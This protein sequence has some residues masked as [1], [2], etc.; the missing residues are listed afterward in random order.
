[1]LQ[2]EKDYPNPRRFSSERFLDKNG[3][4]D[5]I[6][7]DSTAIA[8]GFDESIAGGTSVTVFCRSLSLLY[9]CAR[10]LRWCQRF[11]GPCQ[12]YL[13]RESMPETIPCGLKPRSVGAALLINEISYELEA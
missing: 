8:F 13:K 12:A 4:I 1:M 11:G 7:R 6:V 5:S 3:E 2:N 9:S 10:H